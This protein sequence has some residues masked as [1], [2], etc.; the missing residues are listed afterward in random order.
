MSSPH[1]RHPAY[2][3]NGILGIPQATSDANDNLLKRKREEDEDTRGEEV[4]YLAQNCHFCVVIFHISHL[5]LFHIMISQ[6]SVEAEYKR[7]RSQ[8]TSSYLQ[9]ASAWAGKWATGQVKG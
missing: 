2:S 9:Q 7:A 1:C 8:Y 4:E 3:I 5:S 6:G